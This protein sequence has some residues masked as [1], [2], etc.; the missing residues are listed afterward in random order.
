MVREAQEALHA[1]GYDT[2]PFLVLIKAELPPGYRG[3]TLD[4]GAVL[5][6]AAF[7]SQAML[8]HVLEEELLHLK[9]KASGLTQS[10]QPGSARNLEE[11]IHETRRFPPPKS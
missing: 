2:S 5:G 11:A 9:Q 4:D 7:S 6:D 1:E 8:N 3:M 10:F